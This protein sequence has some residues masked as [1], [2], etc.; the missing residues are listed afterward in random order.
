M[1]I[2]CLISFWLGGL[3]TMILFGLNEYYGAEDFPKK[4][5]LEIA[6]G[7]LMGAALILIASSG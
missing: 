2:K 5:M 3:M 1:L 6:F 7:V 4:L